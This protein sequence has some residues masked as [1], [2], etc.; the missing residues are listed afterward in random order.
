VRGVSSGTVRG[1]ATLAGAA[2]A[3]VLLWVSTQIDQGTTGGYWAAYGVIAA[4][5]LVM[6]LAQLFGGWTKWGWPR[7]SLGVLLLG[8][9]PALVAVGWVLLAGQPEA[10]WFQ[11]HL[12]SWSGSIG[13]DGLVD[14]MREVLGVLAF[15]LGL[16]FGF[17]FDT[18]GPPRV[19]PPAERAVAGP[20]V[21]ETVG[22]PD[23]PVTV[24]EP[25]TEPATVRV[26]PPAD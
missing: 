22:E 19:P 10:N 15:G 12:V 6:A 23:E 1:L 7:I 17:S 2:A 25:V 3:G 20:L 11:R 16:I 24:A 4:G 8:F 26:A 13:I 5:G 18:T 21:A 9:L 14:D